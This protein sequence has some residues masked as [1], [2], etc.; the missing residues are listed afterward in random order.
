MSDVLPRK[1][2]RLSHK[3]KIEGSQEAS[4]TSRTLD[5]VA[6]LTDIGGHRPVAGASTQC[7]DCGILPSE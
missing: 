4:E 1:S 2:L 6:S 5:C 3:L 7:N